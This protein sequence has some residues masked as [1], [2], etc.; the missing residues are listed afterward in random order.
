MIFVL[1]ALGIFGTFAGIV[2]A[3]SVVIRT[4]FMY[5]KF[6]SVIKSYNMLDNANADGLCSPSLQESVQLLI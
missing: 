5:C 6:T 3:L 2:R 1:P 4:Q